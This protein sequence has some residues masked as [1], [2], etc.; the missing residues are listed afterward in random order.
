[1]VTITHWLPRCDLTWHLPIKCIVYQR[2]VCA[3]ILVQ[4]KMTAL[5]N[6]HAWLRNIKIRR[7]NHKYISEFFKCKQT[8]SDGHATFQ[9]YHVPPL[10]PW[11]QPQTLT[12]FN[13]KL[14]LVNHRWCAKLWLLALLP[15]Q[16]TLPSPRA[17]VQLSAAGIRIFYITDILL[18]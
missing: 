2:R 7:R 16:A 13:L 17:T 8:K 5:A 10:C 15:L 6:M 12:S 3:A 14:L 1:M 11:P 9:I 4:I 18:L